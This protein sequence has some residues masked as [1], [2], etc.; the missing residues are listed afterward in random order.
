MKQIE[1]SSLSKPIYNSLKTMILEK[2]LKPGEK[3]VQ[4]KLAAQLGVSRT[5]LMQALQ[6]LENEL[7]VESVPRRGMFVRNFSVDEMID[8]Y[9]CRESIECMAV[10]LVTLRADQK[11]IKALH[12]LF[13]PFLD[14]EGA[15][16]AEKYQKVDEKFHNMLVKLSQNPVLKKMSKMSQI[17]TLVHSLGL[18][19]PPEETLMEHLQI[20]EAMEN[21]NFQQAELRMK[22]HIKL[23]MELLQKI[24][25]EKT[26]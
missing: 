11:D 24:R 6:M 10:R 26:K 8:I 12:Q 3:L 13:Q 9:Y 18:L 25:K 1:H 7:L 15:I 2:E 22:N 14:I 21:G 5:P 16:D 23:S 4:E 19:R 20:I 17:L